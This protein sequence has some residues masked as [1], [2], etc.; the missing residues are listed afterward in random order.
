MFNSGNS[1]RLPNK[2]ADS[3]LAPSQW[4]MS[5][6]SNVVPHWL[7]ANLELAL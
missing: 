3:M 6:Q 7:G 5:L 1:G 4:E 2:N